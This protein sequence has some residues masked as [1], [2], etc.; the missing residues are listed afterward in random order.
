VELGFKWVVNC[1]T[2]DLGRAKYV[3]GRWR[4]EFWYF[5]ITHWRDRKRPWTGDSH[6]W[7]GFLLGVEVGMRNVHGCV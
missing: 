7:R 1:C 4:Q 5:L 2:L 3:T 6:R